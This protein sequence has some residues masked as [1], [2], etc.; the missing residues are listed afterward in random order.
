MAQIYNLHGDNI[1]NLREYFVGEANISEN[2]FEQIL[3]T[4]SEI[5]EKCLEPKTQGSIT[6]LIYGH[7]QSGKTSV[8]LTTMALAA[9]NGYC[10]FVV[11]TSDSIDIYDQTL[12]RIKNSLDNF[13]VFGKK[14]L[15][16][17]PKIH[18]N[19]PLVLVSSKNSRSYL[20]K[21][22]EIVDK[23]EWQNQPVIIIDDEADQASLD[24]NI[25]DVTKP[26]SAVN[27]AIVDLRNNLN[28]HSYLQTTATPQCLLLQDNHSD[29]RPSFV[30]VTTPGKSYV[31]GNYLF[32]NEN[33]QDSNH[34]RLV[35]WLDINRLRTSN[36]IPSTVKQSLLVFFLGAAILRLQGS[37]KK[38]T[39]LLH[40]SFKKDDHHL[41]YL[42]VDQFKNELIQQLKQAANTSIDNISSELLQE[43]NDVYNDLSKT[44]NIEKNLSFKTVIEE[45]TKKIISTEVVEIN[46]STGEGVSPN[47][48]RRHTIYIGGT[49][50]GRGVTVKNL[51]VTY[52]GR[53]AQQPQM[54]TVLQHARMYGYRSNE[55]PAIR[56]YLPNRLAQRFYFIHSSDNSIREKCQETQKPIQ[57]IP[58]TTPGVRP[59]RKNVLN[60]NTV[61]LRTYIAGRSYFPS[62]PISEALILNNQTEELDSLLSQKLYPDLKQPY[63]V[64][65]DRLIEILNYNFSPEIANTTWKD[66]LIREAFSLL[67]NNNRYNNIGN[68]VVVNRNA[69][70]KKSE[71]RNYAVIGGV[72]PGDAGVV[73]YGIDR[74]YPAL[75]MTRTNGDKDPLVGW[76]GVPFWIPVLRFPDGN[77]AFS[78]NRS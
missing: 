63:Q 12:N 41:A 6:G 43:L 40:T 27:Q 64:S 26:T 1:L 33:F 21:V 37:K 9:D 47:P 22:T 13:Q 67:R 61:D 35:P 8:I 76:D 55:L 75:L 42:L 68:L 70:I 58:L 10:R 38:Y 54:D 14:E 69:N 19:S 39:Y 49:K 18:E 11:I 4:A 60:E 29:F 71:S 44:F 51:L 2:D 74:N 28:F 48:A 34:V 52:Y 20:P 57:S 16:N 7:I 30:V 15:A 65:L 31:G 66:T 5:F 36:N 72:L 3:A 78:V 23:L 32:D 50:I 53:D 46:S 24:T 62:I 73:P 56:I 77:Y 25:N 17:C 59:T 45:I